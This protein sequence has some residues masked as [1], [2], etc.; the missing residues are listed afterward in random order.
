[1]CVSLPLPSRWG[2]PFPSAPPQSPVSSVT[3]GALNLCNLWNSWLQD[4]VVVPGLDIFKKGFKS[5]LKSTQSTA[6]SVVVPSLVPLQQIFHPETT[7]IYD[8]KNMPRVVYCIHALRCAERGA[9]VGWGRKT[10]M[11][12]RESDPYSC[13]FLPQF[14]PVQTWPGAPDPGSVWEGQLHRLVQALARI[15]P[16]GRPGWWF[17]LRSP[18][19]A[20]GVGDAGLSPLGPPSTPCSTVSPRSG[21]DLSFLQHLP[22][23]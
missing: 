13:P 15:Y 23:P 3:N 19:W 10:Y 20:Q 6:S 17:L 16:K 5:N 8:K 12:E 21:W 22:S 18:F 1:M 11:K 7:D 9:G 14:I 4:V 2:S